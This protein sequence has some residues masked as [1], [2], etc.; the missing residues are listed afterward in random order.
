MESNRKISVG[1]VIPTY[2]AAKFFKECIES[3]LNQSYKVTQIIVCDDASMDD[4]RDLILEYKNRYPQLIDHV[5]HER[6]VGLPKNFNSGLKKIKTEYVSLIAGDDIWGNDKLRNEVNLLI[7]D[8]EC[9]YSACALID[10]EGNYVKPFKRKFDGSQGN[11]LY[12]MLMHEM[13]FRSPLLKMGIVKDV[14]YFNEN[15]DIFE[16]WDLKIKYLSKCKVAYSSEETV[17]YRQ[18]RN[19]I[20]K[21]SN[22]EK[23]Y[24]N[25]KKVYK[26]NYDLIYSL[27]KDKRNSVL[28]RKNDDLNNFAL[29]SLKSNK[30]FSIK[31]VYWLKEY[32]L[33]NPK[34]VIMY[35]CSHL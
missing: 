5:F 28:R 16:D 10:E 30:K 4:T 25:L 29:K 6:N 12:E 15:L 35:I 21:L 8:I 19:G 13:A 24:C 11:V 20:S 32:I 26:L 7:N 33:Q 9:V 23:Y 22:Y 1:V 14:G 31:K 34:K 18:H 3:V 27:E 2:N 17:F